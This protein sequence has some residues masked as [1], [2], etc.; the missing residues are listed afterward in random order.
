MN[1]IILKLRTSIIKKNYSE[2]TSDKMGEKY[3]SNLM[4]IKQNKH[5][6]YINSAYKAIRKDK[7]P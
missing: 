4:E 1:P 5:P 2:K 7:S 6:E 3:H